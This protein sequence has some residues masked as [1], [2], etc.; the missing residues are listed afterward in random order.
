[1]DITGDRAKSYNEGLRHFNFSLRVI[2]VIKKGGLFGQI[3]RI[4]REEKYVKSFGKAT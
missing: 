2:Q 1:M 3:W 4:C